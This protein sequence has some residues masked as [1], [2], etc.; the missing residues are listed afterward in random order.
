LNSE[1]LEKSMQQLKSGNKNALEDIYKITSKVVYIL[2]YSILRSKERAEDI[3]QETFIMVY[4]KIDRYK[5]NTNPAA[6]ICSIARNLACDEY[7]QRRDI[8]LEAFEENISD[9]NAAENLT[10]SVYLKGILDNLNNDE[11]EVVALFVIGDFKHREIAKIV[12]KPTGTVQWLYNKALKKL[13]KILSN[14]N[15]VSA[16]KS[17]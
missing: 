9:K 17:Q 16:V 12:R 13:R 14:E 6:W 10:A 4:K 11:K 2:A 1:L 7:V 15:H 8:S 3:V 5:L